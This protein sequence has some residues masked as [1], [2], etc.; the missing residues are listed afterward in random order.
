MNRDIHLADIIA[1]FMGKFFERRINNMSDIINIFFIS[2]FVAH[3]IIPF[4]LNGWINKW[5]NGI[6]WGLAILWF[7]MYQYGG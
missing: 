6:G 3:M 2:V 7:L 1:L 5:T 4:F